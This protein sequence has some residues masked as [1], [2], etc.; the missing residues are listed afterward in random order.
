MKF[1]KMVVYD[2]KGSDFL[3]DKLKEFCEEIEVIK[4]DKDF[5]GDMKPENLAGADAFVAKPFGKY[6]KEFLS[7]A[8]KLK[9]F[10]LI[11]TGYD[12]VDVDFLKSK[13]IA[14]T[15]VP[16]YATESVAELTFFALLNI[17]RMACEAMSNVENGKYLAKRYLGW[18]LK[19]KTIGIIGLGSIG[20]RV[21]EIA[22]NFGMNVVYYSK[23]KQP[24]TESKLG[25]KYLE[26]DELL[27][28]A[29]IVSLHCSLNEE[30]KGILGREQLLLLKEGAILLD[31]ARAELCDLDT[32]REL[33]DSGKHFFWFDALDEEEQRKKLVGHKNVF[34]TPHIGWMTK[35]AQRRLDEVAVENVKN[36]IEGNPTNV[37]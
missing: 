8:D 21:A 27:K 33:A 23:T 2:L 34:A 16:H 7:K 25:I 14:F 18:E 15:N 36:F 17:A 28:S 22:K 20:T 26:L 1:K 19:G 9:Y 31:S 4:T 13:G 37:V 24:E 6:N 35:E 5:S 32:V 10:G 3:S 12:V 11:S 30:S 29:D